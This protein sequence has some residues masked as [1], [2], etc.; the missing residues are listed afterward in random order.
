VLPT[1]HASGDGSKVPVAR[2]PL[3]PNTPCETQ[4]PVT[5]LSAPIGAGPQQIQTNLKA[6]GAALRA[7][8]AGLLELSQLAS[9]TKQQGLG[10]RFAR[11]LP[12]RK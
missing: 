12:G 3:M 4:R 2:P 8:N 11:K 10:I 6:P 7:Q 1:P 9:Q 5:D